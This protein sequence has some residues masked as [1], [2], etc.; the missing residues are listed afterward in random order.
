MTDKKLRVVDTDEPGDGVNT[1]EGGGAEGQA[2]GTIQPLGLP[3]PNIKHSD[4]FENQMNNSLHGFTSGVVA[5]QGEMEGQ[6]AA[7]QKAVADLTDKHNTAKADLL[8]RIG[9]LETARRMA[10][11]ALDV[12]NEPN[13]EAE[14][15]AES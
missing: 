9:D 11:A 4:V 14:D 2:V 8:R 6:E 15:A 13:P 1:L 3:S 7:F 5:L 12:K 10:A